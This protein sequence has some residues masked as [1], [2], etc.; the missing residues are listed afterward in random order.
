M[1]A[2]WHR[3]VTIN[4]IFFAFPSNHFFT[5]SKEG[6]QAAGI[7]KP[8]RSIESLTETAYYRIPDELLEEERILREIKNV[9]RLSYTRQLQDFNLWAKKYGY[10]FILEVREGAKLSR[11]LLD[12]IN[13]GDIILR[14]IGQ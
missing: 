11:P 6:E 14:N 10:T 1:Q 7:N 3:S 4:E 5:F 13:N 2:S 8:K 12:A 9:S